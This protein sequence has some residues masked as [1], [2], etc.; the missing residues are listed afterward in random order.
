MSGL[1]RLGDEPGGIRLSSKDHRRRL[2]L[3]SAV[4]ALLAGALSVAGAVRGDVPSASA[5]DTAPAVPPLEP[6]VDAQ[7]TITTTRSGT[8]VM[9]MA[10]QPTPNASGT[11]TVGL[12]GTY[13]CGELGCV[14]YGMNWDTAGLEIVSG[15]TAL[16]WSCT[17]KFTA[18]YVG[19]FVNDW[20]RARATFRRGS[21]TLL[22]TEDF[23]V[24]AP[25]GFYYVRAYPVDPPGTQIGLDFGSV[26]YAVRSGTNPNVSTC[27]APTW[28]V[29]HQN[30]VTPPVPSCVQLLT[31]NYGSP[32]KTEWQ[33]ALPVGSGPWGIYAFDSTPTG[34]VKAAAHR[35]AVVNTAVMNDKSILEVPLQSAVG[36]STTTSSSTSTTSS[37]TTTIPT[38]TGPKP[39]VVTAAKVGVGAA[40][41]VRGRVEGTPSTTESV[42][43]AR[44]T[45]PTCPKLMSGAGVSTVGTTDVALGADGVGT[46]TLDATVS[47]GSY[48]YGT[49]TAGADTSSVGEC[50]T[51]PAGTTGVVVAP[52]T[53]LSAFIQAQ[54]TSLLGRAASS[55]EVTLWSATLNGGADPGSLDLAL[56]RSS[57]ATGA[58]DPTTRLY[59][60]YLGRIP[61]KGGLTYW[62]GKKR[63]G[64]T[65]NAISDAFSSSSEFKAKYGS[66]SNRA[67]VN[68]VYQNVLGR[69]GEKSGV[70]YWTKKLD[71]KARTRGQVMVGFSESNEYKTKKAPA[72]DVAVTWISVMQAT[73]DKASFDAW[74]TKLTTGGK[75]VTDLADYL[76]TTARYRSLHA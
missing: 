8:V 63:K 17:V 70:D 37:T 57:D 28:Y 43:I 49:A 2:V 51:V 60:A 45:G 19:G 65:L 21:L 24:W 41:I 47:A 66:L 72:V 15:C 13:S 31:Q 29:S 40:G 62:I 7:T 11:A 16:D 27:E 59:F 54:Y 67:F 9:S 44:G 71:T 18:G 6:G 35:W 58:V 61:D 68:L 53:S 69:T 26:A 32:T 36:G 38:G 34:L 55:S 50:L 46:F 75:S 33:S 5:L 22:R 14:T 10:T 4:V 25:P 1:R 30:D 73:P 48:L 76:F 64:T 39:P 74:V 12:G 52:F 56:R 3:L 42:T 20:V 23:L